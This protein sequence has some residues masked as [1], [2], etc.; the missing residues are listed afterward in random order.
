MQAARRPGGD[1][2][3]GQEITACHRGRRATA[4]GIVSGGHIP[5][6]GR[7]LYALRSQQEEAPRATPGARRKEQKA[8]QGKL[9]HFCKRPSVNI[10]ARSAKKARHSHIDRY[11]ILHANTRGQ[12]PSC[13]ARHLRSRGLL[14]ETRRTTHASFLYILGGGLA[15]SGPLASRFSLLHSRLAARGLE[16]PLSAPLRARTQAHSTPT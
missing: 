1:P 11:T 12:D 4:A 5:S 13:S 14:A 10:M 2:A 16:S 6:S 15:G 9:C 8:P 3:W 7:H